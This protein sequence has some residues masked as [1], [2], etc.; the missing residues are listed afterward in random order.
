MGIGP[1][2][3]VCIIFSTYYKL[4]ST[5]FSRKSYYFQAKGLNIREVRG[6]EVLGPIG[7]E[8]R[9]W[10]DWFGRVGGWW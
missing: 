10:R 2:F 7:R 4:I 6:G 1:L 3:S 8:L 5:A 9:G